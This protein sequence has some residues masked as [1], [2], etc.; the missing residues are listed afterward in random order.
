MFWNE[1][2]GSSWGV[3]CDIFYLLLDITNNLLFDLKW[4]F[5]EKKEMPACRNETAT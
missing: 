3:L 1:W 5:Y 4:F 2:M